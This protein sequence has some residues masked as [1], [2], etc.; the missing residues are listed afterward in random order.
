MFLV[1]FPRKFV[2]WDVSLSYVHQ[3]KAETG[4]GLVQDTCSEWLSLRRASDIRWV[5]SPRCCAEPC[6]WW[7]CKKASFSFQGLCPPPLPSL[8]PPFCFVY[9]LRPCS[10]NG[11]VT[12]LFSWYRDSVQ[13]L[14]SLISKSLLLATR[15]KKGQPSKYGLDSVSQHYLN[16]LSCLED[17]NYL[18]S[19]SLQQTLPKG[20]S[21]FKW[22]SPFCSVPVGRNW[23]WDKK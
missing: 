13:A 20:G 18:Y 10:H 17:S 12:V 1:S 6:G 14:L 4:R 19:K 9:F 2:M 21:I 23:L 15:P 8:H 5:H 22:L 16:P 11:S 7:S 3:E